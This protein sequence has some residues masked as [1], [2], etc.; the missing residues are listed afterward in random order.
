MCLYVLL[1]SAKLTDIGGRP[2]RTALPMECH[3]NTTNTPFGLG[4][5]TL[6]VN[7]QTVWAADPGTVM[8]KMTMTFRAW[9]PLFLVALGCTMTRHVP[10]ANRL[11]ELW[12]GTAKTGDPGVTSL[13]FY[14]VLHNEIVIHHFV[15]AGLIRGGGF[16]AVTS[17]GR[18]FGDLN[19]IPTCGSSRVHR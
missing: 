13:G 1:H 8:M 11:M 5:V 17:V 6:V 2:R 16:K 12:K 4:Q 3:H 19:L 15:P 18:S 7:H 10:G 14:N 9:F